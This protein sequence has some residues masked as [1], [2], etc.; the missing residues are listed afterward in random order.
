MKYS[1]KYEKCIR[2][3][4]KNSMSLCNGIAEAKVI[5]RLYALE[6]LALLESQMEAIS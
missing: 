1:K 4:Q 5:C 6:D 2:S 3:L